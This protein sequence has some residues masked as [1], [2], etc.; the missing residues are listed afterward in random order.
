MTVSKELKKVTSKRSIQ[1]SKQTWKDYFQMFC[2]LIIEGDSSDD[3]KLDEKVER[4]GELAT[5]ALEL[6]ERRWVE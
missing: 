6:T 1:E 5:L 2:E 3:R 4:A